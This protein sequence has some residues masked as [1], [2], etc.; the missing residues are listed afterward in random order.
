MIS[1][2]F[3]VENPFFVGWSPLGRSV[4]TN[5]KKKPVTTISD[6][7][8]NREVKQRRRHLVDVERD[9]QEV[10]FGLLPAV[11]L[12]QLHQ[13]RALLRSL[14]LFLCPLFLLFARRVSTTVAAVNVV[15]VVPAVVLIVVVLVVGFV[16]LRE[17]QLELRVLPERLL[18]STVKKKRGHREVIW[19]DTGYSSNPPLTVINALLYLRLPPAELPGAQRPSCSL[20]VQV[21]GEAGEVGEAGW[22]SSTSVSG[23]TLHSST[24][25]NSLERSSALILAESERHWRF[26]DGMSYFDKRQ[27]LLHVRGKW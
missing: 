18:S 15:L 24:M 1:E 22:F 14:I 4:K 25:S 16:L 20:M 13:H 3:Q 17:A 11:F 8:W 23:F 27:I 6:D 9:V 2:N 21:E 26:L 5:H 7:G 12:Q 10:D 19:F